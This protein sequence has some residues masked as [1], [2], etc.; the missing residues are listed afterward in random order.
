MAPLVL[1][2]HPRIEVSVSVNHFYSKVPSNMQ[3][4]LLRK[5]KYLQHKMMAICIRWQNLSFN[6]QVDGK[7]RR[8][9]HVS[10][11]KIFLFFWDIFSF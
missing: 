10:F 4:K 3:M 6:P 1:P 5:L 8:G 11:L 9:L 7:K 2:N